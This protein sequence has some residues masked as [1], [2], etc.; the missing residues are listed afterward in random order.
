VYVR[1]NGRTGACLA[2]SAVLFMG[3][4][5][6]GG[7]GTGVEAV[8]SDGGGKVTTL[9]ERDDAGELHVCLSNS[10]GDSSPP[11]CG[12]WT[13]DRTPTL[14]GD[15][16]EELQQEMTGDVALVDLTLSRDDAGDWTVSRFRVVNQYG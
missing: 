16:S 9:V 8:Y 6:S 2:F 4:C 7:Q 14:S 10:Q 5:G 11:T 15:K 1:L 3:A 12:E 13:A